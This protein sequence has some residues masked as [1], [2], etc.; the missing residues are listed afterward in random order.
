MEQVLGVVY[1]INKK[2]FLMILIILSF[3][4]I[5]GADP[6]NSVQVKKVI[7][8][9]IHGI[10]SNGI[11][12]VNSTGSQDYERIQDAINDA[13]EGDIIFIQ[14][15]LYNENIKINK[16][17]ELNG[18]NKNTVII[19][20]GN[21]SDT[22][23]LNAEKVKISNI[24][25]KNSGGFDA[26]IKIISN[27][28]TIKNCNILNCWDGVQLHSANSTMLSECMIYENIWTGLYLFDSDENNIDNCKIT[29]NN[30]GILIVES[31][32]NL[33]EKC[34][35]DSNSQEGVEL[36]RNSLGNIIYNNKIVSNKGSGVF[37]YWS[38]DK[39]NIS[40]CD[41]SKNQN[42][43]MIGSVFLGGGDSISIMS[44]N[45]SKNRE[46]GIIFLGKGELIKD[47]CVNFNNI[48]GNSK[49]ISAIQAN[50]LV[51]HAEKN[52]WG[53][54][55]GPNLL[56]LR[57]KSDKISFNPINSKIYFRP[58]LR[59][60]EDI[61]TFI[62]NEKTKHNTVCSSKKIE[63]EEFLG[64]SNNKISSSILYVGGEYTQNYSSI[65]HAIDNA[66]NFDTIFVF[67]GT[68]YENL[69]IK[70]QIN[71][72][73][74][75]KNTVIID[76]GNLSDTIYLNAEKVKISNI[77]IKNSGGF[78]AG[79]KIISN[80]NTIKNCNI[81]NCWDGIEMN[82]VKDNK[83]SRCFISDN[84]NEGIYLLNSSFNNIVNSNITR[85]LESIWLD[86][87]DNNLISNC[88]IENNQEE[89]V[90]LKGSS[91]NSFISCKIRRNYRGYGV[92]LS[93]ESN[94]NIISKSEISE[95]GVGVFLSS[96]GKGKGSCKT[97]ITY[98]DIINN[99]GTGIFFLGDGLYMNDTHIHYNNILNNKRAISSSGSIN[100]Y[101]YANNNWWGSK[102]GPL[103]FGKNRIVWS[104]GK[105]KIYVYPL[106][107]EE[108]QK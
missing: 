57:E 10:S 53:S 76:G 50:N 21:L 55:F 74:E 84:S 82:S 80:N 47:T 2:K 65:Q 58:Y 66:S 6:A 101:I 67:N 11:I 20:G 19:D 73:G 35:I 94:S 41:I 33:I 78:D 98:C 5:S 37:N 29:E 49:G 30:D 31:K 72:V 4:V 44:N 93:Y 56:G 28:N 26:G 85:N 42:G 12:Y 38:S 39:T 8:K 99:N 13:N 18:E 25:I 77:T 102:F 36:E 15:G 14:A 63:K 108:M 89:G 3:M 24:T 62:E 100:C 87:S 54:K 103:P 45:I 9:S 40:Q 64:Y 92:Y 51:L 68:Y 90:Q 43:I 34:V 88:S 59:S 61:Q 107:K 69:V 48:Y 79:I 60:P 17:I 7:E 32:H 81:L 95:N 46:A 22:I 104:F 105:G 96:E 86:Y 70:K 91:N 97:T 75:N 106:L 16:R 27:N 23:Y 52:W 71:L 1:M 83:I